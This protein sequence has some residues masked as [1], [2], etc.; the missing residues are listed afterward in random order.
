MVH[1]IYIYDDINTTY[2]DKQPA[3]ITGALYYK[4][5]FFFSFFVYIFVFSKSCFYSTFIIQIC[6]YIVYVTDA[7]IQV[8]RHEVFR[9]T[10]L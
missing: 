3:F 6:L 10:F 1:F 5:S 4:Y 7:N 8:L 2:I 9:K